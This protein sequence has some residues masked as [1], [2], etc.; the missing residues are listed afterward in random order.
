MIAPAHYN[1]PA[2]A[3]DH[4]NTATTILTRAIDHL[5]AIR[6]TLDSADPPDHLTLSR[7]DTLRF[8]LKSAKVHLYQAS[9]TIMDP[10][11]RPLDFT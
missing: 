4:L 1:A 9:L 3:R 8:D 10:T 6:D 2:A 7:A 11:I 5:A